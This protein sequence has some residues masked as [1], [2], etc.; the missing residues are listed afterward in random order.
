MATPAISD[1]LVIVRGLNHVFAFGETPDGKAG[2]AK[3]KT[4]NAEGVR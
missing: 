3:T 1:G 2:S 4:N